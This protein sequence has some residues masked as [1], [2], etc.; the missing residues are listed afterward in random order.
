M[1]VILLNFYQMLDHFTV[2]CRSVFK[3]YYVGFYK[4]WSTLNII[5]AHITIDAD[6]PL[7]TL[8]H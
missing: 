6:A 8:T 7:N 1:M 4:K 2:W 5:E 3:Y